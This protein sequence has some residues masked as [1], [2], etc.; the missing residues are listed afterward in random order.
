MLKRFFELLGLVTMG[1]GLWLVIVNEHKNTLC[2]ATENTLRGS[3]MT[4]EC[5]HVVY[6]YFSGFVLLALGVMVVI[7]GLLST[8]KSKKRRSRAKPSA[9]STY[10]WK[11]PVTGEGPNS[12]R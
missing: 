1:V 7:F 6:S 5:S 2:N 4:T 8:R 3:V 9:A 12:S 10:V 11:S